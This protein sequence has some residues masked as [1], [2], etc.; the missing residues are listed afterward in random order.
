MINTETAKQVKSNKGLMSI[1]L[2]AV[3]SSNNRPCST[4]TKS[5]YHVC[6]KSSILDDL[7][8]VEMAVMGSF[9]M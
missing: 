5:A 2:A 6:T 7:S 1:K 8:G 3:T 4:F 9:S